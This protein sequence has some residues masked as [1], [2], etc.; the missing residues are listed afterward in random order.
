MYISVGTFSSGIK[1]DV[2]TDPS[3]P[4]RVQFGAND[5]QIAFYFSRTEALDLMSQLEK[6]I[7]KTAEEV[8][9]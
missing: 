5:S 7:H 1:V 6:A 4:V 9:A 8:V 3:S 2:S